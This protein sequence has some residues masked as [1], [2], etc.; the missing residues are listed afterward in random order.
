MR[1]DKKKFGSKFVDGV[2]AVPIIGFLLSIGFSVVFS[3]LT[4]PFFLI[5]MGSTG[6]V[7]KDYASV[8][9]VKLIA[10]VKESNSWDKFGTCVLTEKSVEL[11]K[12]KTCL[13]D[14]S[15][16]S[17]DGSSKPEDLDSLKNA[18]KQEANETNGT[19]NDNKENPKDDSKKE[20]TQSMISQIAS[21]F[22]K[23]TESK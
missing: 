10:R 22:A 1:K 6:Y 5:L 12:M 13:G 20:D 8:E 16:E 18:Q 7:F 3:L 11:G 4:S 14:K 19:N 15:K 9:G 21:A 2:S 17:V 23:S